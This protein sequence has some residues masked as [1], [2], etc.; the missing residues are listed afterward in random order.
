MKHLKLCHDRCTHQAT[1][2]GVFAAWG[3]RE[4][5]LKQNEVITYAHDDDVDEQHKKEWE[6]VFREIESFTNLTFVPG[7][8]WNDS[9]L[10]VGYNTRSGSWSY[11]GNDNYNI[12][13]SEPTTNIGWY[14]L[15]TKRHESGHFIGLG[16]E[17]QTP[18]NPIDWNKPYVTEVMSGA[19]NY[20]TP[21][22]TEWNFFTVYNKDLAV[23]TSRDPKSIM[24][25]PIPKEFTL[26]GFSSTFNEDWSAKD[27]E[28]LSGIYPKRKIVTESVDFMI[29]KSFI[30]T[31]M[32]NNPNQLKRLYKS[33]MIDL[34]KVVGVE[35]TTKRRTAE[36]IIAVLIKE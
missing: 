17:H 6:I 25:Y 7:D 14:G 10:R 33:E 28:F 29:A 36:A 31:Y 12:T 30:S 1:P 18:T 5:W 15:E 34:A 22:Q 21:E 11:V 35:Y 9:L 16:H 13:R 20:W 8:N 32:N 24:M 4:G 3:L 2:K 23:G 19:P 27:I 26:D